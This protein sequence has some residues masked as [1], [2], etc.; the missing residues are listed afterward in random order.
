M[1]MFSLGV[2]VG[3]GVMMG[4]ATVLCVMDEIYTER[5][6]ERLIQSVE[7]THPTAEASY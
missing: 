1:L 4:I 2:M 5:D 7:K 6:A 3:M